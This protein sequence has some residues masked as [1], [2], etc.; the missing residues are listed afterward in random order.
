MHQDLTIH[1]LH[2]SYE[3]VLV[4]SPSQEHL[5]KLWQQVRSCHQI[6]IQST[7][8]NGERPVEYHT[9]F[10]SAAGFFEDTMMWQVTRSVLYSRMFNASHMLQLFILSHEECVLCMEYRLALDFI[11]HTFLHA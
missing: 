4:T 10:C 2:I 6:S 11:F 1:F 9:Q 3:D 7:A 5:S 8:L